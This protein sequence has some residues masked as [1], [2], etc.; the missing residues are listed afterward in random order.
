MNTIII[1]NEI[2]NL[3]PDL[4]TDRI[5]T[6]IESPIGILTDPNYNSQNLSSINTSTIGNNTGNNIGYYTEYIISSS[7]IAYDNV[8]YANSYNSL[9]YLPINLFTN[10][11]NDFTS[12]RCYSSTTGTYTNP[13]PTI[14]TFLSY[15]KIIHISGEWVQIQVPNQIVLKNYS[16]TP[17]DYTTNIINFPSIW[18]LIG[19]ND[20]SNWVEIDHRI[21]SINYANTTGAEITY[22]INNN[23]SFMYYRLIFI[24]LSSLQTCGCAGITKYG[25]RVKISKWKLFGYNNF[26]IAPIITS[27]VLGNNRINISFVDNYNKFDIPNT[28]YE[29]SLNNGDWVDVNPLNIDNIN[30]SILIDD[31][32]NFT[33]HSV[34]LRSNS[35]N[36]T[37][38]ESSIVRFTPSPPADA[39]YDNTP[40]HEIIVNK[41]SFALRM[42]T[43]TNNFSSKNHIGCQLY[44]TNLFKEPRT[45]PFTILYGS[46]TII[47]ENEYYYITFIDNGIIDFLL[48]I[49][50]DV[51][52]FHVL[53]VGGGGGG[54][55]CTPS[56]NFNSGGGGGAGGAVKLQN[57]SV[58]RAI[59]NIT[60]GKGGQAV[61]PI[62]PFSTNGSNSVFSTVVALGGLKGSNAT[63]NGGQGGIGN[64]GGGSGGNGGTA[65][66]VQATNGSNGTSTIINL[67]TTYYGGGGGGGSYRFQPSSSVGGLGGGG[68]GGFN[69]KDGLPNTGGGG[70]GRNGNG[71]GNNNGGQGGSGI[72]IIY[73][74]YTP[75]FKTI[76]TGPVKKCVQDIN[77]KVANSSADVDQTLTQSQRA[78]NAIKYSTGGRV[79]YGNSATTSNRLNFMGRTEGQPG[80]IMGPVRNRF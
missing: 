37:S 43:T 67:I 20:G 40:I 44:T 74:K 73:F 14:S 15:N 79:V 66:S 16:L 22:Y 3:V 53:V 49:S 19:S 38:S 10:S 28:S 31:L 70:A 69:F 27:A 52:D 6:H 57:M 71:D 58:S 41:E 23:L 29:Y 30:K 13:S 39:V 65:S 35:R 1:D 68:G 56:P 33:P 4:L 80:G 42:L 18:Y 76:F 54:G 51:N 32:E 12:N 36:I 55:D 5:I 7:S 61:T 8:E 72:V 77:K 2:I 24:K 34:Q 50:A 46:P 9:K 62:Q 59:Y 17:G 11:I 21:N 63:N 45:D 25:V 48:P 60:V 26:P 75:T 64:N 78:V 47:F